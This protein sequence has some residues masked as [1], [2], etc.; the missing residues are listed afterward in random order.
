MIRSNSNGIHFQLHSGPF[1]ID[2]D[3]H[4]TVEGLEQVIQEPGSPAVPYYSTFIALPPKASVSITVNESGISEYQ[5]VEIAP[6]PQHRLWAEPDPDGI[7]AADPQT[8]TEPAPSFVKDTAVYNLD[9]P[10]PEAGYKVSE[11]LYLRDLRMVE[12]KLFPLRYNPMRKSLTQAAEMSVQITFTG[13]VWDNLNPAS[14]FVDTQGEAWH[15]SILNFD[16]AGGWRGFPEAAEIE[17]QAFDLPAEA[18]KILVDKEGIYE[19]S[20]DELDLKGM[21]LPVD[22]GTIQMMHGGL[23][24]AFQFINVNGDGQ[25]DLGDKIRFYGWAFDGSRYEQMYVNDNVFWLWAGGSAATIPIRANEAGSGSEVSS[26][27]DSVS[28]YEKL[29]NFSG[30]AVQWENEPTIWHTDLITADV[31]TTADPTYDLELPDP[32]PSGTSNSVLVE[33]TT[34]F[35]AF[36]FA[37]PTYSAKTYLNSSTSFGQSVWTGRNNFNITKFFPISDFKQPA[38]AGYPTNQVKVEIS[39]NHSGE[40][41]VQMTRITVDYLRLMNAVGDQLIFSY[42]QAGQHDFQVSGFSSADASAALVWDI[43]NRR[44]PEQIS[45]EAGNIS[46]SGGDYTYAIGR[47]QPRK[48]A[49]YRDNNQQH[50]GC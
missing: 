30:W 49:V 50:F 1:Q 48:W 39:S 38:D 11:P 36:T 21:N 5:K 37:V 26:F 14:G 29:D 41:Q 33:L 25:F 35:D 34:K 13:A 19:I 44:L 10:F 45:L 17:P 2:Q 42:P 31:G 12:L 27:V 47:T 32:D 28:K 15:D 7:L 16:Q 43:S 6:A 9:A 4:I 22:P 40:T 3:G 8:V 23:P 46:G 20:A 24:V 18:F